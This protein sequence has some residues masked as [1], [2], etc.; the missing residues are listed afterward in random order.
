MCTLQTQ[1][2]VSPLLERLGQRV[3]RRGLDSM[4]QDKSV[5]NRLAGRVAKV[6]Q[7]RSACSGKH[8]STCEEE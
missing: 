1:R 3:S 2:R 8:A 7:T 6:K 4:R 5:L